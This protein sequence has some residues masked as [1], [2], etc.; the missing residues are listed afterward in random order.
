MQRYIRRRIFGSW[1]FP[2][3]ALALGV[4]AACSDDDDPAA[5]NCPPVNG[6]GG[7]DAS[8]SGGAGGS[9]GA[10]ATGGGVSTGGVGGGMAGSGGAAGSDAGGTGGDTTMDFAARMIEEGRETF[11]F[12]TFGSEDFWGGSL[13]LHRA[14]AGADNGGVG[15]GVTP[16]MALEVLG[17]KVDTEAL[18]AALVT[19][20]QAGQVD[21]D[22]PA[23]TLA[24][25]KLN[26][27]VGVTGFFDAS[28]QITSIGIQCAL[29]HST[30][31]NSFAEGIGKRLD[32]W[33]NRD[34]NV[35]A[36]IAAAPSL[37]PFVDL[38][39]VDAATVRTVLNSWGEGKFDAEMILDGK[40]T[41]PTTGQPSA[42]VLPAAFGLAGVNLH[43]YTGWGSVTH[44]NAL[45]ANLEMQGKGTFYDPRLRD[46]TKFPIAAANG[47]DNIR[48]E[49]DRITP[50]LAALHFYQLSLDAPKP[51]ADSFDAT[52]AARGQA[53]FSGKAQ[54]ATCHVPPLYT[55]PGWNMHTPAEIGIE[56]FQADRSP[57]GHYRTTPLRGL[58]TRM[59]GGFYHDGRFATLLNVVDHY[60]G[61]TVM[62]LGLTP[63]EKA[64]LV[65]FLKSL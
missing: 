15:D 39:G 49:M 26:A 54:C 16:N 21:L 34:L 14:V 35:G 52:A 4:V 59:K 6:T 29:C 8:A 55:E 3:S 45:V 43:T 38:L 17:L 46:A 13:E 19:Q 37:Q 10:G 32:G 33:P 50:K 61:P 41:N 30:V 5:A 63:T 64:D 24:L 44:W 22:D 18:P 23:T 47:F 1:L 12:D 40:T 7:G 58:F 9:G 36:I 2:A 65:E 42:T 60:D 11:R 27:V 31:D 28:E 20:I 53:L 57:D 25:L 56:S 62:A 48:A 51:P